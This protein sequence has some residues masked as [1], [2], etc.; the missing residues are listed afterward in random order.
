MLPSNEK[1][2]YCIAF[3]TC[4]AG[5]LGL[6][7]MLVW[8]CFDILKLFCVCLCMHVGVQADTSLLLPSQGLQ[9]F[10]CQNGYHNK[11]RFK[12]HLHS[13]VPVCGNVLFMFF[14]LPL[15]FFFFFK[16]YRSIIDALCLWCGHFNM[17]LSPL[18]HIS[19]R[20]F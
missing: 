19:L 15:F 13:A 8:L 7:N 11:P 14:F 17:S 3:S 2:C 6:T 4:S 16:Q 5:L 10:S 1:N 9:S 18:L 20:L 12:M